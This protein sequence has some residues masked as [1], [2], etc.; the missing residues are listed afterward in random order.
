MLYRVFSESGSSNIRLMKYIIADFERIYT[1]WEKT[2]ISKDN[3]PFVLYTFAANY[4]KNRL[5]KVRTPQ[6]KIT[7]TGEIEQRFRLN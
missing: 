1:E 2:T 4:F 6:S 7:S 3:M 5:P